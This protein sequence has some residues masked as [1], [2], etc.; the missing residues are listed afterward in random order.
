VAPRDPGEPLNTWALRETDGHTTLT[1]TM[2]YESHEARDEVL[3]SGMESGVAASY[4]RLDEI[5]ASMKQKE[6]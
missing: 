3:N 2:R 1:V 4:D 6:P 5:L